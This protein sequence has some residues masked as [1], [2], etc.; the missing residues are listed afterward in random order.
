MIIGVI[1][2]IIYIFEILFLL[3]LILTHPLLLSSL[4]AIHVLSLIPLLNF[5]FILL[6]LALKLYILVSL[7]Y[8]N[9]AV[10]HANIPLYLWNVEKYL[11][12][13]GHES[14]I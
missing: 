12:K 6:K 7:E 14:I 2:Y 13:I 1:D 11:C 5:I 10:L 9:M 3:L 8:K 4:L